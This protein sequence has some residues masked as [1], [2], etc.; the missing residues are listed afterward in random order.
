MNI[1]PY[2]KMSVVFIL[3]SLN[4]GCNFTYPETIPG[5]ITLLILYLW[6]QNFRITNLFK[7]TQT[8]IELIE[9]H[10]KNIQDIGRN[11]L[12]FHKILK[13]FK[14]AITLNLNTKKKKINDI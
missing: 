7:E 8:N 4:M 12:A 13:D 2:I 11:Q 9:K 6:Y 1:K 10:D 5:S 14:L 3:A